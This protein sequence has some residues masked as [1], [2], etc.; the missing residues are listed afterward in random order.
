MIRVLPPDVA[1]EIAAGEVVE[2]PASVV[3][4]LVDNAIDAGAAH[5]KVEV[6]EA[7]KRLIGV[8][9]NGSG[10]PADEIDLSPA[11]V[12][13]WEQNGG[14]LARL[15]FAMELLGEKRSCCG[16]SQVCWPAATWRVRSW[17]YWRSWRAKKQKMSGSIKPGQAWPATAPSWRGRCSQWRRCG[18]WYA[19]SSGATCG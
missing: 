3:K 13:L 11:Q 7:G 19:A 15:G 16:P 6:Q 4:E 18:S 2:R 8:T 17:R 9:D 5:I 14:L 10:I 12:A 1:D